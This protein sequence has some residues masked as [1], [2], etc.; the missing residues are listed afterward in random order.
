VEENP[1]SLSSTQRHVLLEKNRR[2]ELAS[3][4][5][6]LRRLVPQPLGVKAT[7]ADILSSTINYVKDITAQYNLLLDNHRN[8]QSNVALLQRRVLELEQALVAPQGHTARL[9]SSLTPYGW[10]H[11]PQ[12]PQSKFHP[13]FQ[14]FAVFV[15]VFISSLPFETSGSGFIPLPSREL[16][17]FDSLASTA[18]SAL[19]RYLLAIAVITI[20]A[21]LWSLKSSPKFPSI[22]YQEQI[23]DP[24]IRK[25]ILRRVEKCRNAR[26]SDP[27]LAA[28]NAGQALSLMGRLPESADS[29]VGDLGL[30][31][32]AVRLVFTEAFL[33]V[34][35]VQQLED[36]DLASA[37]LYSY[38][39]LMEQSNRNGNRDIRFQLA[40]L[41]FLAQLRQV[42]NSD[43]HSG[44]STLASAT[45]QFIS[46][47]LS[48]RSDSVIYR[49]L[50][51]YAQRRCEQIR[52]I[53]TAT[54]KE[55]PPATETP[56]AAAQ[57]QFTNDEL[58]AA[59][60]GLATDFIGRSMK[61]LGE[62]GQISAARAEIAK[63]VA[64]LDSETSESAA[65]A[66]Q[67]WRPK[68]MG[69][70]AAYDMLSNEWATCFNRA[71][72]I[73]IWFRKSPAL[74]DAESELMAATLTLTSLLKL[75]RY[76]DVG[77]MVNVVSATYAD[78]FVAHPYALV[79]L[80][81]IESWWHGRCGRHARAIYLLEE[82]FET[83]ERSV[84]TPHLTLEPIWFSVVARNVILQLIDKWSSEPHVCT[85]ADVLVLQKALQI[86]DKSMALATTLLPTNPYL[87][88]RSLLLKATIGAGMIRLVDLSQKEKSI[89]TLLEEVLPH[90]QSWASG[91]EASLAECSKL[92]EA[93]GSDYHKTA[94]KA[95][96]LKISLDS[97]TSQSV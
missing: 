93:L 71:M 52:N 12:P 72:S 4:I 35:Q 48:M 15:V 34:P 20:I 3:A 97:R 96:K 13:G 7:K 26:S 28:H 78:S 6:E 85:S 70:L 94:Q 16:L 5:E 90:A 55:D 22:A 32:A 61:L 76:S 81:R 23:K 57:S 56:K 53:A 77:A 89:A 39:S 51:A 24:S 68:L 1:D 31:G 88:P 44:F 8:M 19:M 91:T 86:A 60:S 83:L 66:V 62:Q 64:I 54:K 37:E 41:Q 33:S 2:H 42:I 21:L 87:T 80:R 38:L 10:P 25:K 40:A 84:R 30:R 82:S 11:Q 49:R 67:F 65:A 92:C 79:S 43:P 18:W 29:L 74:R 59:L 47:S 17:S 45:Y 63:F 27:S 95:A 58:S 69:S 36:S 46:F 14:M 9:A 73:L 50:A 75:H